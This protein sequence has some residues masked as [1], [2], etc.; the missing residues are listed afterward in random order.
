MYA[1]EMDDV[2]K[3]KEAEM[4][5]SM[6]ELMQL[7]VEKEVLWYKAVYES[8]VKKTSESSG[9]EDLKK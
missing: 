3:S 5:A 7:F 6:A 2:I 1:T 9:E 4:A 8:T